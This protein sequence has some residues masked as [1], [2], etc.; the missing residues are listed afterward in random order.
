MSN[1]RDKA[2]RGH[3]VSSPNFAQ[4]ELKKCGESVNVRKEHNKHNG[5]V[6]KEGKN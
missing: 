2:I 5:T 6:R 1:G 3:Y 4:A